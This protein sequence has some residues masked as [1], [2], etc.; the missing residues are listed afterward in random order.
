MTQTTLEG[1]GGTGRARWVALGIGVLCAVGCIIGA[2]MPHTRYDFFNAYLFAYWFWLGVTLGS[3]ALVMLHNLT[4]G[5]WGQLVRRVAM[6]AA[7]LSPLMLVLFIPIFFGMHDLF[8]W[9]HAEEL[10]KEEVLKHREPYLN[11]PFFAV[12][13]GLYF[14]VWIGLTLWVRRLGLKVERTGDQRAQ[15]RLHG[16]SAAGLILYMVSVT[17][18]G[19]DW[20]M[21]RDTEFYSTTFGF[22]VSTGQTLAAAAFAVIV[23]WITGAPGGLTAGISPLTRP[24]VNPPE[25]SSPNLLNDVGNIL[26]T[27]VI[28]WTYVSFMQLLV[29][30]M[31]NTREDNGYYVHRGLAQPGAWRW[32]GLAIITLHFFVPFF[33]LLFRGTKKYMKSLVTI[34]WLLFVM[35][36]VDAYWMV[37]PDPFLKGPH[38]ELSWLDFAAWVGI[39]GIW[40]AAF[41]FVLPTQLAEGRIELKKGAPHG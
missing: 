38:F 29:I 22:I 40:V 7:M 37:R 39:G 23:L 3:M 35:H 5:A 11:V 4:G 27:L 9:T 16:L 34:A 36:V 12:R 26:L 32:I 15:Q 13:Y 30:W 2:I 1:V 31:G 18:A 8:P 14:L 24:P 10:A 6:A 17:H 25:N 20:V 19:T 33:L 41:L 21:S 28:L